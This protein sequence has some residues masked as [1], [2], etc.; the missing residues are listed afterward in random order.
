MPRARASQFASALLRGAACLG[1]AFAS[2]G[3]AC[4]GPGFDD[5]DANSTEPDPTTGNATSSST[6]IVDTDTSGASTPTSS[7]TTTPPETNSDPTLPDTDPSATDDGASTGVEGGC[8]ESGTYVVDLTGRTD[9]FGHF[10][11]LKL[12]YAPEEPEETTGEVFDI[13]VAPDGTIT[14]SLVPRASG[15][16]EG[17]AGLANMQ[18]TIDDDCVVDIVSQP[19]FDSD[20]GPFGTVDATLQGTLTLYQPAQV[21]PNGSLTLEGGNIP[22]GPITYEF[23][24]TGPR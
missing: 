18:G 15:S 1:L 17:H 19:G 22:S 9:T 24:I 10:P 6:T 7:S 3:A 4:P 12:W 5:D 16:G 2:A 21:A 13:V 11:F 23:E 20:T 8:I 14:I